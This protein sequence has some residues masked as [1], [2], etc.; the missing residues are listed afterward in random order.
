MTDPPRFRWAAARSTEPDTDIVLRRMLGPLAA[1]WL[2][3]ETLGLLRR[4][5]LSL[6]PI[7]AM[8]PGAAHVLCVNGDPDT[9]RWLSPG[10][11]LPVRWSDEIRA[12]DSRLPDGL[13]ETADRARKVGESLF[14]SAAESE[15]EAV[16]PSLTFPEPTRR[17]PDLND[18]DAR[19]L[20]FDSAFGSLLL[21]YC[22][23]RIAL[24]P[25][26]D[27]FVSVAW[28]DRVLPVAGLDVKLATAKRF[29]A[30][31]LHVVAP[32]SGDPIWREVHD[33]ARPSAAFQGLF[34]TLL[35]AT[36]EL[37]DPQRLATDDDQLAIACRTYRAIRRF[38]PQRSDRWY[39]EHLLDPLAQRCRAAFRA[40][41]THRC[42]EGRHLVTLA[43]G[44]HLLTRL[45]LRVLSPRSAT[46][47]YNEA[48]RGHETLATRLRECD[49]AGGPVRTDFCRI[50]ADAN[51]LAAMAAAL[52]DCL[53]R[54]RD[55]G[56][57]LMFELTGGS[58]LQK[59]LLA[60]E[61]R[62]DEPIFICESSYRGPAAGPDP[63]S[64]RF[65]LLPAAG[66]Q[67]PMQHGETS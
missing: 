61:T 19:R 50:P 62:A 2:S 32:P 4:D 29:G 24:P 26:R 18:P 22:S 45:A 40:V 10:L 6:L 55:S 13:L 48:L 1:Y 56:H 20:E 53:N 35:A 42:S 34:D 39:E 46:I 11:V 67:V 41:A 49:A 38:D 14:G 52:R 44:S 66:D 15:V 23:W 16:R 5:G 3:P 60:G 31:E 30:T 43:T 28:N 17:W 64:A 65:L 9:L 57:A 27:V 54:L 8:S 37:Q 12:H 63:G 58:T 25:R 36:P 21:G 47:F 7:A 33:A 59:L 51:D